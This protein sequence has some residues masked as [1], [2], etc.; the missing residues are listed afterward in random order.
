M[1][2]FR[3]L[4]L[5]AGAI[6]AVILAVTPLAAFAQTQA[7]QQEQA[8]PRIELSQEQEKQFAQL[9]ADAINKIKEVLTPAQQ[10]QFAAA[11]E[12]G[13]GLNS[14]EDLSPQQI[15]DIQEILISFNDQL[16]AILTPQQR[17][18]IEQSQSQ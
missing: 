5:L 10:T 16:G 4:R 13:A 6:T 14:I 2:Q 17:Q 18:Q 12:S 3:F 9:Q 8:P 7:P 11:L 15:S 1:I